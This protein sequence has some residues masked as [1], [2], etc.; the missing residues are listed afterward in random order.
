[1]KLPWSTTGPDIPNKKLSEAIA[2]QAS[3][4]PY[5]IVPLPQIKSIECRDN[6]K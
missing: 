5:K 4:A 1:M 3:G 2:A 6:P